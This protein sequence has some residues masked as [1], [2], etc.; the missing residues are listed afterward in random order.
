MVVAFCVE[1]MWLPVLFLSQTPGQWDF[2][3]CGGARD[4]GQEAW[5]ASDVGVFGHGA[6]KRKTRSCWE[7]PPKLWLS[8]AGGVAGDVVIWRW[9]CCVC[10]C[11]A[12]FVA[13]ELF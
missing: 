12:L 1:G 4:V 3:I 10:V 11:C 6:V 8:F 9:V 13:V 2:E 5:V 7:A